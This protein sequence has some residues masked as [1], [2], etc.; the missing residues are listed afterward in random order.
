MSIYNA[1]AQL[2][3]N[4][5]GRLYDWVGFTPLVFVSAAVTALAWLVVPLVRVEQIEAR[6]R[7]SVRT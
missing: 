2:S 3:M 4:V 7:A 6:A 5:G 1:G